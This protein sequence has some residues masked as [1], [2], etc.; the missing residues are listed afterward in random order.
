MSKQHELLRGRTLDCDL[1]G[2]FTR[3]FCAACHLTWLFRLGTLWRSLGRNT[4]V[5]SWTSTRTDGAQHMA[6]CGF[7][8]EFVL[9]LEWGPSFLGVLAHDYTQ[10]PSPF[11]N[12]IRLVACF[13]VWSL[14]IPLGA[15]FEDHNWLN[16]TAFGVYT[17]YPFSGYG[18]GALGMWP[19]KR[20]NNSKARWK[21]IHKIHPHKTQIHYI[22][23]NY[24]RGW[25]KTWSPLPGV[26]ET[27][28]KRRLI[29]K[30]LHV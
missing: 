26:F 23:K 1:S 8:S 13:L 11:H 14:D 18:A 27:G 19:A 2:R 9:C 28:N 10:I 25:C 29:G 16:T 7:L 4:P 20:K 17:I 22:D 15:T 6:G 21:E 30:M 24:W 3:I 5:G 12:F